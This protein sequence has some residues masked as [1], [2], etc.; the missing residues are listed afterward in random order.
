MTLSLLVSALVL[1]STVSGL[2]V[3][4]ETSCHEEQ[5]VIRIMK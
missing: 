3:M 1:V 5:S 2:M 4:D